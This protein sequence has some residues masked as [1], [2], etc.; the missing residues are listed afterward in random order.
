MEK[1]V[2]ENEVCDIVEF[3]FD[4]YLPMI[5][6]EDKREYYIAASSEHAGKAARKYWE[7]MAHNDPSE[8][9]C[10]IGE[11]TLIKWAL[12]QNASPGAVSVSSLEEWLDL[13]LDIPEETF[14]GW[15]GTEQDARINKNMQAVLNIY[16]NDCVV[17]KT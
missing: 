9:T 17:Y 10:I 15:D 11:D 12:G 16:S 2:I 4:S 1:I 8:F 7:D 14:G 13:H 3:Y 5:T 6:L